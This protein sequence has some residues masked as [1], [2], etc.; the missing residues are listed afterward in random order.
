MTEQEYRDFRMWETKLKVN[1]HVK[2]EL[3]TSERAS[4]SENKL[5]LNANRNW[6]ATSM[7]ILYSNDEVHFVVSPL[8]T[9]GTDEGVSS[10]EAIIFTKKQLMK[11]F[12][13]Q[14]ETKNTNNEMEI[15]K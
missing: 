15:R 4:F 1:E 9:N 7:P 2:K 12:D 14:L 5:F 8:I 6:V 11:T 3:K 13:I 10:L